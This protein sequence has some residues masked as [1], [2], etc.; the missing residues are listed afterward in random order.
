MRGPN[1][2]VYRARTKGGYRLGRVLL[3]GY[4]LRG[5]ARGGYIARGI[6][7]GVSLGGGVLL[8]GP[9]RSLIGRLGQ[10]KKLKFY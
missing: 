3:R 10:L 8:R 5:I 2:T 9:V 6:A 4:Y 7:R 1:S